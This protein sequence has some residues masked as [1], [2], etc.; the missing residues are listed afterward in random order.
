MAWH[1]QI[2]LEIPAKIIVQDEIDCNLEALGIDS[3]E[4]KVEVVKQYIQL[5]SIAT[6]RQ[7]SLA[8]GGKDTLIVMDSGE[9][10][11]SPIHVDQFTKFFFT[12]LQEHGIKFETKTLDLEKE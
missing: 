5:G 4:Q 10:I 11:I 3:A 1:W 2:T 6:W 12:A 7:A 8:E 9:Y